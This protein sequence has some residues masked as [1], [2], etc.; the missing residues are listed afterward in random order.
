MP[1]KQVVKSKSVNKKPANPPRINK[2]YAEAIQDALVTLKT[3]GGSSRQELWK[4]VQGRNPNA[5][6]KQF[7]VRLQKMVKEENPVVVNGKNNQRFQLSN[8]LQGRLQRVN[9]AR[10]S[11]GLE[12][13]THFVHLTKGKKDPVKAAAAKAKKAEGKKART[14]KKSELNKAKKAAK[15]AKEKEKKMAKLALEKAKKATKKESEKTRKKAALAKKK[16]AAK[17]ADKK[18]DMVKAKNNKK[19][20]KKAKEDKKSKTGKGKKPAA[21]KNAKSKAVKPAKGKGKGKVGK[22]AASKAIRKSGKNKK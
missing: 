5:D 16:P 22:A 7:A 4:A 6:Y 10:A 14:A 3:R 17:R 18:K 21:S 11:K 15:L 20:A 1:P 8:T 9:K 19:D 2:P 12:K 13:V